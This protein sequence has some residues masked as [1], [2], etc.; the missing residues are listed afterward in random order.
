[1]PW[2]HIVVGL[3]AVAS[4]ASWSDVCDPVTNTCGLH[5]GNAY[6]NLNNLAT[7]LGPNPFVGPGW[8]IFINPYPNTC[9]MGNCTGLHF[10][11]P[12]GVPKFQFM[13]GSALIVTL[14]NI[15]IRSYYAG[16]SVQMGTDD[17]SAFVRSAAGTGYNSFFLVRAPGVSFINLEFNGGNANFTKGNY[18]SDLVPIQFASLDASYSQLIN[19]TADVGAVAV[20]SFSPILQQNYIIMTGVYLSGIANVLPVPTNPI[21]LMTTP[22]LHLAVVIIN[23]AGTVT[24][25]NMD[26]TALVWHLGVALTNYGNIVGTFTAY[27]AT[28]LATF[29]RFAF[30]CSAATSPPN[31]NCSSGSSLSPATEFLDVMVGIGIVVGIIVLLGAITYSIYKSEHHLSKGFEAREQYASNQDPPAYDN[32]YS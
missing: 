12:T 29:T 2:L 8:T 11:P 25:A 3:V 5:S 28:L 1:M 32:R 22:G 16:V 14:K 23:Y 4:Q 31:S 9:I 6:N 26:P 20:V 18:M 24:V 15:T 30:D 21:T 19:I 13:F 7:F 17:S 27:N 10:N